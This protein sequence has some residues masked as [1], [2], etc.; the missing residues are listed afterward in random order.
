[1]YTSPFLF[2]WKINFFNCQLQ[3]SV[4]H[5]FS[6]SGE[7]YNSSGVGLFQD[8]IERIK[9]FIK[10]SQLSHISFSLLHLTQLS[11]SERLTYT[12]Y[13]FLFY[14]QCNQRMTF[15]TVLI[16]KVELDHSP[17]SMHPNIV[18]NDTS[19]TQFRGKKKYGL[20]CRIHHLMLDQLSNCLT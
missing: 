12:H 9:N 18:F 2:F 17:K 1:M 13:T 4:T 6:F 19:L 11:C 10:K 5:F 15:Q 14:F 8:Q 7:V 20:H 3:T 16:L